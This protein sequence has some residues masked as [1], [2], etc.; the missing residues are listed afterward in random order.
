MHEQQQ[1]FTRQG[2]NMKISRK[3]I[4]LWIGIFAMVVL[5]FFGN[6]TVFADET[7]LS[8]TLPIHV[9]Y[10]SGGLNES[11]AYQL[12]LVPE[13]ADAPMPAGS[14]DG[15]D[16]IG[17]SKASGTDYS[18]QIDYTGVGDYWYQLS[19]QDADGNSLG[20][21]Q[22]HVTVLNEDGTRSLVTTLRNGT[23]TGEKVDGISLV[24][25]DQP[26]KPSNTDKT[27]TNKTNNVSKGTTSSSVSPTVTTTSVKTGDP[28]N[29]MFWKVVFG[30]SA[31]VLAF[32]FFLAAKSR[33]KKES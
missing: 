31:A 13:D 1:F 27:T 23:K 29:T 19:C 5:S 20:T 17:I 16:T 22:L 28:L 25:K 21:W 30:L 6:R 33:K 26:Q 12:S 32:L 2:R 8:M 14:S 15:S 10:G 7:S 11:K 3:R 4:N 18:I 24:D 9:E